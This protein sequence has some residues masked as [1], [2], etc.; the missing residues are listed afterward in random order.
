MRRN[1]CCQLVMA[2]LAH[3]SMAHSFIARSGIHQ[4][5]PCPTPC[6]NSSPSCQAQTV[7]D[8]GHLEAERS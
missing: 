8:K 6:P 4:V 3:S 2:G 7:L 1:N 5:H